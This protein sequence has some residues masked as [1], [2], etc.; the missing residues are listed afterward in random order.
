MD[1][2]YQ[3]YRYE[4]PVLYFDRLAA[5]HWTGETYAKS[6]SKARSNLI[7][8]AKQKMNLIT[9]TNIKLPGKIMPVH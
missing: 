5:D 3:K 2:G 1:E 9:S 4:G 8:Q 7:Y 6:E